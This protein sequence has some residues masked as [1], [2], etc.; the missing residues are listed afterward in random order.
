MIL[1]GGGKSVTFFSKLKLLTISKPRLVDLWRN[2]Y[3]VPQIQR[4]DPLV[5]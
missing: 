1:K 2:G 4:K 3:R 5:I